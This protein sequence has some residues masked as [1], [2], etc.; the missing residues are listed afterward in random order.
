VVALFGAVG[1]GSVKAPVEVPEVEVPKVDPYVVECQAASEG[2]KKTGAAPKLQD[3]PAAGEPPAVWPI[4]VQGLKVP[5][6]AEDY[7]GLRFT[8]VEGKLSVFYLSATTRVMI[9]QHAMNALLSPMPEDET[10]KIHGDVSDWS[11]YSSGLVNAAPSTYDYLHASAKHGLGGIDCEGKKEGR[12]K[13]LMAAH[14]IALSFA[15]ARRVKSFHS[16]VS[17]DGLV[18]D[19]AKGGPQLDGMLVQASIVNP[20]TQEE[21][22]TWS[23]YMKLPEQRRQ[24]LIV[25]YTLLSEASSAPALVLHVGH[26]V[27]AAPKAPKWLPALEAFASEPSKKSADNLKKA[28][29]GDK[30]LDKETHVSL[31][32]VLQQ[33][34]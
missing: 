21:Y 11:G 9:D 15:E 6:P 3:A 29:K 12:N 4:T 30:K 8:M 2:L 26:E 14:P 19:A 34:N 23:A 7:R 27:A 33:L 18:D 32:Q 17:A 22:G 24:G 16:P 13:I 5:L 31:E 28:I 10:K 20:A 1:C 25:E